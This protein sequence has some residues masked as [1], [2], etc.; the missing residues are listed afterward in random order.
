VIASDNCVVSACPLGR[1][2]SRPHV[3]HDHQSRWAPGDVS[4]ADVAGAPRARRRMRA[5]HSPSCQSMPRQ[6]GLGSNPCGTTFV[7]VSCARTCC[8]HVA[9][10]SPIRRV[11]PVVGLRPDLERRQWLAGDGPP[12]GLDW[13]RRPP[14]RDGDDELPVPVRLPDVSGG[15]DSRYHARQSRTRGGWN[16]YCPRRP[17]TIPPAPTPKL[18]RFRRPSRLRLGVAAARCLRACPRRRRH[19]ATQTKP[20][21][22][23][24][25]RDSTPPATVRWR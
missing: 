20:S 8:F 11:A 23:A 4:V 7:H 10:Q 19:E 18:A 16:P 2:V 22:R 15:S 1:S 25:R 12:V 9:A 14:R 5:A 24:V 21:G 13:R 17:L 6:N 3:S